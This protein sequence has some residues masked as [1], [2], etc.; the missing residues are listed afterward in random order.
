MSRVE[1]IQAYGRM[2]QDKDY[3][4]KLQRAGIDI[5]AM[6]PSQQAAILQGFQ[7]A[8]NAQAWLKDFNVPST[9]SRQSGEL[10]YGVSVNAMARTF[11][12][13]MGGGGQVLAFGSGVTKRVYSFTDTAALPPYNVDHASPQQAKEDVQALHR[14]LEETTARQILARAL[15]E[16]ADVQGGYEPGYGQAV[17]EAIPTTPV[18]LRA[19]ISK[20]GD[21]PST[22]IELRGGPYDTTL[23]GDKIQGYRDWANASGKNPELEEKDYDLRGF[24]LEHP[25]PMKPGEHGI[26]K[27][28]KPSHPTFSDESKYSGTGSA[29]GGR[30]ITKRDG[31]H[32]IPGPTNMRN[33]TYQQL[34]EYFENYEPEAHLDWPGKPSPR[35]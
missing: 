12:E 18:P 25:E 3:L 7:F 17:R 23:K 2:A 8:P 29:R 30:W 15:N 22:H 11:N 4:G 1:Q 9:Q 28:K 33:F 31:T 27:F 21:K 13:L 26:D 35:R 24:Y 19:D 16:R 5:S 10:K 34:R 14:S 20:L 32:F 6:S